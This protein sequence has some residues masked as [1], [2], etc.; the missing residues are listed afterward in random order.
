MTKTSKPANVS[1]V[2]VTKGMHV[3][4]PGV[5]TLAVSMLDFSFGEELEGKKE[6]TGVTETPSPQL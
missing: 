1:D 2:S 5:V 3:L 4:P 6:L